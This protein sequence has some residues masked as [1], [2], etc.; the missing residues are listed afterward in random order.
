MQEIYGLLQKVASS[1]TT[2]LL[3]GESGVGKEMIADALHY[4]GPCPEGPFIKFN[5]AALPEGIVESELFGHESG[6]FTGAQFRTGKFERASGGSIFLDEV[7]ELAPKVQAKLLRILQEKEFE[8]VGGNKP[9]S[10]DIRVIAATNRDLSEMVRQGTFREDLFYRLNV[11]PIDVPPL[12]QRG[13]DI[14]TL[15]EYFM[16]GYAAEVNKKMT[17]IST[18]AINSMLQYPWPGNVRELENAIHRAVILADDEML[19]MGHLPL[20]VQHRAQNPEARPRG[21]GARLEAIEHEMLVESLRKY[22]GNISAAAEGLGLTRRIMSL[23]LKHFSLNYKDF[24]APKMA[25]KA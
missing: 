22:G 17:S 2:V 3:L 9:I 13:N 15:A 7:G 8:R 14:I 12:R 18:S 16:R 24:R 21:I 6:A 11:F 4:G 5:C 20:A 1:K 10:V 19:H 25:G 23:R